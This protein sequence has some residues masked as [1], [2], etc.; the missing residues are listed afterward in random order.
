MTKADRTR[1]YI[2]DKSAPVF[3]RR[4]IAGTSLS[5][6]T[7]A[8]HL[9]KGALYGNFSSKDEIAIEAFRHSMGRVRQAFR[10]VVDLE[11]SNRG[12]I[13]AFL[14]FYD[15][16]V[17]KP[18]VP[19]GCPF[20]NTAVEADD[21]QTFL[22]RAVAQEGQ[23]VI[24]FLASLFEA[25]RDAGEFRAD[26]RPKE[27]GSFIF[28]AVEGAIV[29]ARVAGSREPMRIVVSQCKQIVKQITV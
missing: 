12:K 23:R 14:E 20:M 11:A 26:I 6:L 25:G 8:T 4:G 3:N 21:H 7:E 1:Q 27:L 15:K 24:D 13:L 18:P 5:D 2:I 19:G 29:I 10:A 9:T 17:L 28:C 16:N 22:R